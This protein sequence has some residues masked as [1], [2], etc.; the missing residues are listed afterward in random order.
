MKRKHRILIKI[1][2]VLVILF[3][4]AVIIT[5]MLFYQ[6][7]DYYKELFSKIRPGMTKEE[8]MTIAGRPAFIDTAGLEYDVWYYDVSSLFPERPG[9]YFIK[10]DSILVRFRWEPIDISLPIDSAKES[11]P[12]Y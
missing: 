2:S 6:D 10:G 5:Y 4:I 9:C 8:I 7:A 11:V 12:S 1:S 3:L